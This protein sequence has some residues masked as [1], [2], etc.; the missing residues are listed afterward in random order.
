VAGLDSISDI[1][2]RDQDGKYTNRNAVLAQRI[3]SYVF[4][5]QELKSSKIYS[6][7]FYEKDLASWLLDNYKEFTDL[8]PY[9]P[10]NKIN[11]PSKIE[12][13]LKRIKSPI[14][15]LCNLGLIRYENIGRRSRTT[16]IVTVFSYTFVGHFIAL[17]I[18]LMESRNQENIS[19]KIY[20]I[21][22]SNLENSSSYD[23][24]F[25]LLFSKYMQKGVF[26]EFLF[27]VFVYRLTQGK[28]VMTKDN[29]FAGLDL[30]AFADP[31]K[32]ILHAKMLVEVLNE[33][34]PNL[35]QLLFHDL[36][37]EYQEAIRSGIKVYHRDFEERCFELRDRPDMIALEGKCLNCH[38]Y[39]PINCKIMYYIKKSNLSPHTPISGIKCSECKEDDCI[40]SF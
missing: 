26:V 1:F 38:T 12:R 28:E 9:R 16:D 19:Q 36:K 39:L 10:Y 21:I 31:R 27:D 22:D 6:E 37:L 40:L 23:A 15:D 34:D 30:R 20:A 4:V 3:L 25:S 2:R 33:L 17:I 18:E 11:R 14:D 5:N 35:R 24:F 29:L 7:P 8:Y 13:V 32:A